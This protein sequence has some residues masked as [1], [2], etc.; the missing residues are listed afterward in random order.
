MTSGGKLQF[1][2][3]SNTAIIWVVLTLSFSCFPES[4]V[5]MATGFRCP[6]DGLPPL[7]S[8]PGQP[9]PVIG[10]PNSAH[11]GAYSCVLQNHYSELCSQLLHFLQS[12]IHILHF[13]QYF[14]QKRVLPLL[15]DCITNFDFLSICDWVCWNASHSLF[16]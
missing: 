8:I 10:L 11:P 12:N 5:R 9:P 7:S 15:C 2:R 4:E 6:V 13:Q 14:I 16:S 1:E 3:I